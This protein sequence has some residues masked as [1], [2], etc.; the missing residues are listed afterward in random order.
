M[1]VDEITD[2]VCPNCSAG[3]TIVEEI[4]EVVAEKKRGRPKKRVVTGSVLIPLFKKGRGRPRKNTAHEVTAVESRPEAANH[5]SVINDEFEDENNN[6]L[7]ESSL[8]ELRILGSKNIFS[9]VFVDEAL[10]CD[11][12]IESHLF[13]VLMYLK[14]S[15]PCSHCGEVRESELSSKLTDDTFPLCKA[16]EQKGRGAGKRRKLRKIKPK[17]V[18]K[19]KPTKAGL[20]K[21]TVGKLI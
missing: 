1:Q 10:T 17:P 8:T 12:P 7:A 11:S 21:K 13:D 4:D 18:K 14:Q 20:R 19:A 3:E 6:L 9:K 15:L 16:Y 2:I 5:S